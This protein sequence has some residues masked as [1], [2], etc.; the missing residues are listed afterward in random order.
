ML[1]YQHI[2]HAGNFADIHKHSIL[3][4]LWEALK[5]ENDKPALY[6]DTHAGRGAYDLGSKEAQKIAEYKLGFS[7]LDLK[8]LPQDFAPY[9]KAIKRYAPR[10][11]GSSAC[12]AALKSDADIMKLNELHPQEH[13]ALIKALGGAPNL[14]IQKKDGYKALLNTEFEGQGAQACVMIDP[15]YEVK[16]E[17]AQLA[18]NVLALVERAPKIRMLIWYPILRQAQYHQE[19]LESLKLCTAPQLNSQL[20]LPEK[21][22]PDKG[23][24]ATGLVLINPPARFEPKLNKMTKILK[25]ALAQ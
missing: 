17:Y 7:K 6:I 20:D 15:S 21:I 23:M 25:A 5:K 24:Y 18:E 12:I 3:C 19:M 22:A 11:P 13:K 4:A 14:R 9:I 8:R 2:Y 10:Y 16:A 1:S